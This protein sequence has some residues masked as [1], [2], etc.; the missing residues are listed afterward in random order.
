M[1]GGRSTSPRRSASNT[2][3]DPR[4]LRYLVVRFGL[5][6]RMS[7]NARPC[8]AR[9]AS[10]GRGC[11][12]RV[13]LTATRRSS[14]GVAANAAGSG[15][16]P[17]SASTWKRPNSRQ[18]M[19]LL[20]AG[21]LGTRGV[22]TASDTQRDLRRALRAALDNGQARPARF[23]SDPPTYSSSRHQTRTN[24]Q[25]AP[26]GEGRNLYGTHPPSPRSRPFLSPILN[27]GDE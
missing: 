27:L 19:R 13:P 14:A 24:E 9:S 4:W 26:G 25:R 7:Y 10:P 2:A 18:L 6:H 20:T 17:G 12:T 8:A 22:R 23:E 11:S 5:K 3:P 1:P 16:R 21:G 15:S